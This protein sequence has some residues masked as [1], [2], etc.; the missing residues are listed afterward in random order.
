MVQEDT[1]MGVYL[2]RIHNTKTLLVGSSRNILKKILEHK[3]HLDRLYGKCAYE[4]S[5]IEDVCD[6]TTL[7]V[8]EKQYIDRYK[9]IETEYDVDCASSIFKHNIVSAKIEKDIYKIVLDD[10]N[11]RGITRAD[12]IRDAIFEKVKRDNLIP[13]DRC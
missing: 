2:I 9:K 12:W 5:V 6:A 1:K 13:W 11:D 3:D 7:K 10:I 4:V 8:K